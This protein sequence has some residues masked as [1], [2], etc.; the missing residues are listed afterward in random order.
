[1]NKIYAHDDDCLRACIAVLQN[2][3]MAEVPKLKVQ[4][5]GE[6]WPTLNRYLSDFDLA[7]LRTSADSF[8]ELVPAGYG[9]CLHLVFGRD[10]GGFLRS[11]VGLNGHIV[12]DP[13]PSRPAVAL[14]GSSQE[15]GFLIAL[16][17][18]SQHA[19]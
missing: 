18:G 5:Q 7:I 11:M 17:G 14:T 4:D 13:L 16:N 2:V 15:L 9:D 19:K 8:R 1:M 3:R 6:S 12:F 10:E